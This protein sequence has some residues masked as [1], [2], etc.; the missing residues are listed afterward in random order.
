M[1]SLLRT[2]K[3]VRY[4]AGFTRSLVFNPSRGETDGSFVQK[5]HCLTTSFTK[6]LATQTVSTPSQQESNLD[7][8]LRRLDQ[9]VRR[10]GRIS[11]RELEDVLEELRHTR[12]ATGT[13]SLLIIRCCGN[14]VPEEPP[15]VRTQLVQEIWKTLENLG[16]PMD[17][18][19]YNALL[20]VYLENEHRFSPTEFLANLERKGVEP[21]RVTYQRLISRYCQD[22]DIEGATRILEFMR[23]KQ[24]PV[25]ENVFNALIMGHSQADDM[26]SATGI[27]QVMNQAGLEPSADTYATLLNGY[28]KRGNMEA[29][30]NL[31]K[32]CDSKEIFLLDKDFMDIIY[33]LTVHGFA[34]HVDQVMGRMRQ[35]AGYNQDA[36][37]LIL[38]L[39]NSGNEDVAMKILSTMPRAI[40]SDGQSL[41]SGSFLI[42]QL[43]R[44]NRPIDKIVA[45]CLQME[46]DEIHPR[47]LCL[48]TETSLLLG[49]IEQSC[50]L[51]AAM[52]QEGHP[53]RHHY[54]WPLLVASGKKE[55]KKDLLE[56]VKTMNLEF[57][58]S[59]G[60]ETVRDYVVPHLID[61]GQLNSTSADVVIN[62]L[63]SANVSLASASSAVVCNLL[64]LH[65][66]SDA[67]QVASRY[68]A[69]YSLAL[70]RKP[71]VQAFQQTHDVQA[72]VSM[73][74]QIYDGADRLADVVSTTGEEESQAPV[75]DRTEVIGQLVLDIV[76]NFRKDK[77]E[78]VHKVLEGLVN[79]GLS[80]SNSAAERL[81]EK[82]GA[83]LTSE[84]SSLLSKLTSGELVPQVLTRSAVPPLNILDENVLKAQIS[85]LEAKGEAARGVK[86]QLLILYC[87]N[88]DMEKAE[89]LM[90]ELEA[91]GFVFSSGVYAQLIELYTHHEKVEEALNILKKLRARDPDF[92]LDDTKTIKLA[93]LL[94][95]QD[96]F[97]D[98][99]QLI[100]TQPRENKLEDRTFVYNS[101]CWRLLNSLA[102]QGRVDEVKEMFQ[103]LTENQFIDVNNVLLGPLIKV[104]L[105]KED[106]SAA[107][108][109]FEECVRKYRATPW[110]NELAS[111]LIQAEDAA[112]L[113][114]LTDLSTQVHGE[115]NSLYDLV[116]SFV[117]CG[118]I[119]Q[120]RKIL[121]TPGLRSR[122]QRINSACERYRQEGKVTTLEG[123]VEATRDLSH[124]DRTDLFH[125]LLLS[126]C[127]AKDV[128]KALGLWTR[129]QEE[130]VQPTDQFLIELG[131]LLQKEGREV[132]FVIPSISK[133]PSPPSKPMESVPTASPP[134]S[135]TQQL[136]QALRKEN[137]QKALEIKQRLV[138][139]GKDNLSVTDNSALIE[140]LVRENQLGEASNLVVDMLGANS[141][142]LPR[143]F[144]FLLN[145][146][147]F[148][149][150]VDAL[151]AIGKLL[152]PETKKMVSFD[153]R[154]CH[155]NVVAGRGSQYL[156][157]LEEEINGATKENLEEIAAKF[158]R[159]G[160]I[161]LL[162]NQPELYAHF[163]K[164]ARKYAEHGILAPINVLWIHAMVTGQEAAAEKL[165]EEFLDQTP[166]VMFQHI[167]QAA[168]EKNNADLA[169]KMVDKL[170]KSKVSEGALGVAYSCLIDV[171]VNS[172]QPEEGLKILETAVKDVCLE[173]FNRTALQRL[174]SAVTLQGKT[175]PYKIPEKGTKLSST[176]SSSSDDESKPVSAQKV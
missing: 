130:D 5:S 3:F 118:R 73:V 11:R 109:Q 92:A 50:A 94:V 155:A 110:K 101:L 74:H 53:I 65:K 132:P 58:L 16:V 70:F 90:K 7:R 116:F 21:N 29:I 126:Y 49:N 107:V 154:L 81:Q 4:F 170:R 69:H 123:L 56:I 122:P 76:N 75:L 48:A 104:H 166:R 10:L 96:R 142:P 174:Q 108:S 97:Q 146:L 89:S 33:T 172:G 37:N 150:E 77:A 140:G 175:F 148:A 152:D 159:G 72:Y 44:A 103:A 125:H 168:R 23:E 141:H 86:R 28:A 41:P 79:L 12:S 20:R 93:S 151:V 34:E 62:Q 171:L 54:F 137:Y 134:S 24:L 47:A 82:L 27:I 39:V 133:P 124:I 99:I 163:E 26:E 64:T 36:V 153:N 102:E 105:V 161:G 15:E 31:L 55:D 136:K 129:M 149:G 9:D 13:Q 157:S 139:E 51:L 162:E 164:V 117:E 119:R 43:V 6:S 95:N 98:A 128:D 18:S 14:L 135:E 145:R 66:L 35:T 127:K 91:D 19:H 85:A 32:E 160:A 2:S 45:V 165:W 114:H 131:N 138:S 61:P 112:A 100:K 173:N 84:I 147:A 83:E 67:A 17:V 167:A 87:R 115:I 121:E 22:G 57:G 71:L 106:L 38:R 42:R 30:N 143:V 169:R 111:K 60:G 158:P 25:N 144:R 113:Q 120:A 156:D 59:V 88:R 63:R 40:R 46:R 8:S 1:T 80:I 176:S 78:V 68:R 52:K